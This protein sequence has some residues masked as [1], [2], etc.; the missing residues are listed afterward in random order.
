MVGDE[1]RQKKHAEAMPYTPDL[2]ATPITPTDLVAAMEAKLAVNAKNRALR[3]D[4]EN[5]A[6]P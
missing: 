5:A 3:A 6:R 4:A 2:P 1:E